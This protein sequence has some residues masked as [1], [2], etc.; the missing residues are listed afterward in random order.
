[1]EDWTATE[2]APFL[3]LEID[4]EIFL[5]SVISVCRGADIGYVF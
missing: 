4:E 2:F 1:M 3:M 5:R